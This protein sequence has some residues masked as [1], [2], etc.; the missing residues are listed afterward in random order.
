LDA[1]SVYHEM[2]SRGV[3]NVIGAPDDAHP[4]G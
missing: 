2:D 4:I 3:A 1:L